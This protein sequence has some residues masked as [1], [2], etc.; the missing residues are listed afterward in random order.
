MK[1]ELIQQAKDQPIKEVAERLGFEIDSS[2]QSFCFG[3]HDTKTPSLTFYESTNSFHCFGCGKHGDPI[4][5]V[6]EVQ[7]C[8]FQKAVEFLTG[9]D[10]SNRT[11][12]PV[13]NKAIK[14][15]S[16]KATG[17][18]FSDIYEFF[19]SILPFPE[20]DSYLRKDRALT[21]A[22]LEANGVRYIPAPDDPYFYKNKLL[23][24]FTEERLL[25]S[26]LLNLSKRGFS[27]FLFFDCDFIFPFFRND[28]P[29][30][31]QG[32]FSDRKR[33]Y[34]NLPANIKKPNFYLP[35]KLKEKEN[36]LIAEGVVTCL[37]FLGFKENAIAALSANLDENALEELLPFKDNHTFFT[38]P[39]IDRAGKK[40][41]DKLLNLLFSKGFKYNPE[42]QNVRDIGRRLKVPEHELLKVKDF[43]DLRNHLPKLEEVQA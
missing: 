3:N 11:W 8:T 23:S 36:V 32:V 25:D 39:D 6:V 30:Y 35:R 22:I 2:S 17:E 15:P 41:A 4:Q 14:Q 26:G 24:I 16:H 5:L 37:S 33:K 10:T 19:L 42:M 1:E 28:Q 13:R 9:Q 31:L 43:N 38:C 21:G 40:A 18:T 34:K 20:A 12:Q 27:Y 7:K 29:I